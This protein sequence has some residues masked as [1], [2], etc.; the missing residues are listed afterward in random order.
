M[1]GGD[2]PI[3]ALCQVLFTEEG[4][5]GNQE[6][7][8][9]PANSSVARVLATR[10]GMPITLS[11]VTVEVARQAGLQL[12]GIGLPGHF[13]VGGEELPDETYLDPFDGGVLRDRESVSRRVST[14]FGT[15]LS[16]PEE[17][18]DLVLRLSD[19]SP[20]MASAML[21]GL[22]ES[23]ALISDDEGWRIEPLALLRGRHSRGFFSNH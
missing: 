19:G 17:I 14:V 9:E 7:Y 3:E 13:I 11:I 6:S 22:V 2:H 8:D 21:Y 16:L 12:S 5:R 10:R 1:A 23:G 15:P 20:F 18:F 4:M